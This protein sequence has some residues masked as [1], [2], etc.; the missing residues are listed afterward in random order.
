MA[1]TEDVARDLLAA[2]NTDAGFLNA[3]K[4]IDSRYKE[5]CRRFR[6]RHLRKIGE[7]QLP[8]RVTLGNVDVTRDSSSVTGTSTTWN[9]APTSGAQ[10]NWY[11]RA[12]SAWYRVSAVTDDTHLT[13]ETPYSEDSNS[14]ASYNLIQRYH[15][16]STGARWVG[17]MVLSR[18]SLPLRV[19]NLSEFDLEAPGRLIVGSF[20][21]TVSQLGTDSSGAIQV[22]FYPYNDTSEIVH[23]VY[24]DMPATLGITTTIPPQI[25]PGV[26]KEGALIDLYRYMKARALD[27]G[28]TEAAAVYRNDEQAQRIIWDR[29]IGEAAKADRG[30]DDVSFILAA[31]GRRIQTGDI[32]TA[33][34]EIYYRANRAW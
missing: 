31:V 28:N 33:R 5:L 6:P 22:E 32:R 18:L 27:K 3:I 11:F 24:W 26:L 8:A 29:Y 25:D 14:T 17:D 21:E 19:A 16:L 15:S 13:I 20:P 1:T 2:M 12:Q 30:I 34:D 23:Y 4:W 10:P 7:L 9:T